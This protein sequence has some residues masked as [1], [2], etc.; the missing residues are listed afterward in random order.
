MPYITD[1]AL[2]PRVEAAIAHWQQHTPLRFVE[3]TGE[4]DYLSFKR[5]NGCWSRVGRRGGEQEI[6]LGA[7]CGVGAAVHEIGHALGLWHEQS[8]SDRDN[9][10]EVMWENIDPKQGHNFDK[11]IQDGEDLGEYDYGSMMH[12]PATA[13][14]VNGGATIKARGGA[15]IGQRSGLSEGDIAAI[16]KMYP[17]LNGGAEGDMPSADDAL[18]QTAEL[19]SGQS[20]SIT[21]EDCVAAIRGEAARILHRPEDSV[22]TGDGETAIQAVNLADRLHKVVNSLLDRAAFTVT[23]DDRGH[24]RYA[25]RAFISLVTPADETLKELDPKRKQQE[26]ERKRKANQKAW[27][28]ALAK[29]PIGRSALS[30]PISG[31]TPEEFRLNRTAINDEKSKKVSAYLNTL[32]GKNAANVTHGT[33]QRISELLPELSR[34]ASFFSYDSSEGRKEY[35]LKLEEITQKLEGI[36]N[37]GNS[38][39]AP[40]GPAEGGSD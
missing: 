31:V 5:L 17:D 25:N 16:R 12:Y 18:A 33:L 22:E 9:Y 40:L 38:T 8:R 28:K 15:E 13:F 35:A 10:I 37:D 24:I 26:R 39:P 11:H 30:N 1:E 27:E 20:P 23:T 6:S 14:S 21:I 34:Y 36:I 4:A 19:Q 32:R 7:G 3:R 2:R 29:A